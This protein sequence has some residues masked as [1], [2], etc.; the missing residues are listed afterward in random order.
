SGANHR[1][2][3]F[4]RSPPFFLLTLDAMTQSPVLGVSVVPRARASALVP[5][6][7]RLLQRRVGTG[8]APELQEIIPQSG[9]IAQGRF[10]P[11]RIDQATCFEKAQ[12][13]GDQ[14]EKRCGFVVLRAEEAAQPA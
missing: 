8:G 14:L 9:K 6:L 1:W 10:P 11:A 7:H 4:R 3:R 13:G 5:M 2:R 12:P